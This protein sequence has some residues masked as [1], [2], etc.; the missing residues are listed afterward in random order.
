MCEHCT[1]GETIVDA[2]ITEGRINAESRDTYIR[3]FEQSPDLVIETLSA[4]KPDSAR[5]SR[6][7]MASISEEEHAAIRADIAQRFNIPLAE[8]L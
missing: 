7:Y 8:V 6:N 4:A 5:M 2:A 1:S 3:T